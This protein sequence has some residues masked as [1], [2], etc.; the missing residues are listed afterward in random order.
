MLLIYPAC[1]RK[2]VRTTN[3]IERSFQEEKRRTKVF[4][5]HQHEKAAMGFVFGVLIRVTD[6]WQRVKMTELELAHLRKIRKIM[7]PKGLDENRIPFGFAA[8]KNVFTQKKR[9]DIL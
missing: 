4:P 2:Y 8:W 9:L 1:H 5:Q 7:C 6:K 3:L